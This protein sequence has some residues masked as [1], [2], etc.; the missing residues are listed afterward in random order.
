VK[1]FIL[2]VPFFPLFPSFLWVVPEFGELRAE[3][4]PHRTLAS[5]LALQAQA[6]ELETLFS[7]SPSPGRKDRKWGKGMSSRVLFFPFFLPFSR[8]MP[9]SQR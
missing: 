2:P 3:M 4:G 1:H 7:F 5:P 8:V 9:D 6:V